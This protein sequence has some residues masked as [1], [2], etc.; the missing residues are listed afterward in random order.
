VTGLTRSAALDGRAHGIACG[1]IDIGNAATD[2]AA[3]AAAG[4]LQ[5]D[6][7]VMPEPMIDVAKVGD[8]VAWMAGQAPG[9]NVLFMTVMATDMPFVGRG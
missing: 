8:A 6:G 9:T 7:R 1:Q 3:G 5:A 2:M 4:A